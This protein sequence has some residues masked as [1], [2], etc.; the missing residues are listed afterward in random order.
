MERIGIEK[1]YQDAE[2]IFREG[3][4]GDEIYFITQGGVIIS[5]NFKGIMTRI[6]ELGEGEFF[7]EMSLFMNDT[8]SATAMA[9]GRT[10]VTAYDKDAFI[11]SIKEDPERA[12]KIIETLSK[13]LAAVNEEMTKL[14]TKNLLP[15]EEAIKMSRYNYS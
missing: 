9:K 13:R 15:K 14:N 12:I 5:K 6:S 7:G 10:K 3:Q 2:I 4:Q 8:R 11:A 1:K